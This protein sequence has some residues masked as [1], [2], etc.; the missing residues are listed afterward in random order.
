MR[1]LKGVQIVKLLFPKR[2][3]NQSCPF[4][5]MLLVSNTVHFVQHGINSIH[6]YTTGKV[7][8]IFYASTVIKENQQDIPVKFK[9]TFFSDIGFSNW[10]NALSK[11]EKHQISIAHQEAVALIQTTV[12]IMMLGKCWAVLMQNKSSK[13]EKCCFISCVQSVFLEGRD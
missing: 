4:Q 5:S 13:T 6:G 3:T 9:D 1:I 8:M 10:K 11:F 7:E 2:L 12:P